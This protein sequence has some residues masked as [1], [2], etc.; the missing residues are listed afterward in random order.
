MRGTGNDEVRASGGIMGRVE[1]LEP[2][3]YPACITVDLGANFGIH[4]TP[5]LERIRAEEWAIKCQCLGKVLAGQSPGI[6]LAIYQP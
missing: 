4:Y 1:N 3:N 2:D 6:P 5:Q